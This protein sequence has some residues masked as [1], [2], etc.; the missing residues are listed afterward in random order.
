MLLFISGARVGC[1]V[2]CV[3]YKQTKKKKQNRQNK[4]EEEEEMITRN[5]E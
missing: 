3:H 2:K 4:K 5:C 1:T